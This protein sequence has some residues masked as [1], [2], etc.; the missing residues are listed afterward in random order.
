MKPQFFILAGPNG[1]GKSTYGHE[2]VPRGTHMFNGDLVYAQLIEQYPDYDPEKLKG[3]VAVQLEKGRDFAISRADHFAFESN[4]SN[5]LATEITSTFK[6][7][8]YETNLI[9]FGLDDVYTSALR[10]DTRVALGGHDIDTNTLLF[11]YQEG[12]K[13]VQEHMH[14]YDRIRFVDTS[15]KGIAPII[16]YYLQEQTQHAVLHTGVKWFNEHFNEHLLKLTQQK[17]ER[18]ALK[19]TQEETHVKQQRQIR[20]GRRM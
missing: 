7:A 6:H 4:Y 18:A 20:R 8:G 16:A 13:R 10:V 12:I 11:N 19:K 15:V 3:G 2:H 17:T 9:Y 14:L 5:D 1:A